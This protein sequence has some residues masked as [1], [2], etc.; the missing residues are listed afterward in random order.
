MIFTLCLFGIS[1]VDAHGGGINYDGCHNNRK[2]GGYHCHSK[3]GRKYVRRRRFVSK[4]KWETIKPWAPVRNYIRKPVFIK[5]NLQNNKL[6]KCVS[7]TGKM[8]YTNILYL[9]NKVCGCVKIDKEV[10]Q[11]EDNMKKCFATHLRI[12]VNFDCD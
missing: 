8:I 1:N 4:Q 3:N 5:G 12:W 10:S 9:K 6:C 11:L 2:T 7:S